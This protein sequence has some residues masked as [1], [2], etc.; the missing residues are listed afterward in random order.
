MAL[1]SRGQ[2]RT[3]RSIGTKT[4]KSASQDKKWNQIDKTGQ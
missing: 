3:E 1:Q 2:S 4:A